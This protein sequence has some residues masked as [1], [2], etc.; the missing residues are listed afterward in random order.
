MYIT[1]AINFLEVYNYLSKELLPIKTAY[2]ITKIYQKA[3][4]EQAFYNKELQKII[5]ECAQLDDNGQYIYLDDGSIK[6]QEDKLQKCTKLLNDLVSIE[7][8]IPEK[9]SIDALSNFDIPLNL[10]SYLAPFL[11]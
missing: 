7:V 11:E 10:M 8:D 4:Q 6:I 2:S 1:D 5:D 3:Q 9:I